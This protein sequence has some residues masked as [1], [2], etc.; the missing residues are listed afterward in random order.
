MEG[1]ENLENEMPVAEVLPVMWLVFAYTTLQ[2]VSREAT[3]ESE[4]PIQLV[5]AF[6]YEAGEL[7]W[8][9]KGRHYCKRITE[10]SENKKVHGKGFQ[11]K[12]AK[13]WKRLISSWSSAVQE[14]PFG[15]FTETDGAE[16]VAR[17]VIQLAR[18]SKRD[19]GY[20]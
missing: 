9:V 3:K 10:S 15:G 2:M 4:K 13:G 8:H 19:R 5:S 16:L 6:N 1:A 12:I 14:E 11:E 17:R 18:C 7:R 20:C